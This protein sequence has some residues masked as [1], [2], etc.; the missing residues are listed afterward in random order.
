[1]RIDSHTGA[2]GGSIYFIID[3][4]DANELQSVTE[5]QLCSR[6]VVA[7][8][9]RLTCSKTLVSKFVIA[10]STKTA[11]IEQRLSRTRTYSETS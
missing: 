11:R 4:K 3:K 2:L 7:P 8:E 5:R 10:F 6:L 9:G 1:M